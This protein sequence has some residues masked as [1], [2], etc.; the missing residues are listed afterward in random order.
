MRDEV[1]RDIVTFHGVAGDVELGKTARD[2]AKDLPIRLLHG[3]GY[4][5]WTHA[6]GMQER[7]QRF[8]LMVR[9]EAQ[10]S[11]CRR[12]VYL[13]LEQHEP[14]WLAGVEAHVRHEKAKEWRG[15]AAT[16]AEKEAWLK[17]RV[18]AGVFARV[19]QDVEDRCP[20]GAHQAS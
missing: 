3:G 19:L 15:G 17:E 18:D 10:L 20:S 13:Y 4:T 9:L 16:S 11:R 1:L 14:A 8:P 2:A 12:Q 6:H 5:A 7:E